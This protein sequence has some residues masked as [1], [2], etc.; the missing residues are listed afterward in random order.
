MR[1][2]SRKAFAY[3]E[4][5]LRYDADNAMTLNNYAYYLSENGEQLEKALA[6]S[7]RSNALSKSNPTYLDTRAWILYKLGRAAE[8]KPLMQQALSLDRSSSAVLLVHY[9][10]ILDA[11]GDRFMA[12]TYWKRAKEVWLRRCGN[13]Q[14]HRQKMKTKKIIILFLLLLFAGTLTAQNSIEELNRLIQSYTNE[15]NRSEQLLQKNHKNASATQNK[16]QFGRNLASQPA[17]HCQFTRQ[18]DIHTRQRHSLEKQGDKPARRA[19]NAA[20][21]GQYAQM[22]RAAYKNYLTNSAMAFLFRIARLQ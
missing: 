4:K 8:A 13:R 11:L 19:D 18:T 14:T 7:E 21:R 3:Y 9:G 2:N 12:V 10:D 17:R 16:S 15:I 22:I 20:F 6:M 5:A 1:G